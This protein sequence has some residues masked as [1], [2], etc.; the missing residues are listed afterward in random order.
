M[1]TSPTP[2]AVEAAPAN[3]QPKNKSTL[4]VPSP[5]IKVLL[6]PSTM[7]AKLTFRFAVRVL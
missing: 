1:V 7:E 2:L 4:G 6:N 5:I 3:H